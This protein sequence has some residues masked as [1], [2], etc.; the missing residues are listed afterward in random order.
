M[1]SRTSLFSTNVKAFCCPAPLQDPGLILCEADA[2]RLVA[3]EGVLNEL[4]LKRSHL[5]EDRLG[6]R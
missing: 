5:G 6:N 1:F 3:L 4:D 2:Q